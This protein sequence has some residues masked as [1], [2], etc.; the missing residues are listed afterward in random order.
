[1]GFMEKARDMATKAGDKANLVAEDMAQRARPFA[2]DLKHR[3]SPYA[4]KAG[5]LATK[6]VQAAAANVN[7]ATG[8]KYQDQIERISG[9]VDGAIGRLGD[10]IKNGHEERPDTGGQP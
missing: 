5:D 1:M 9:N 3:A 8:G 10:L 2:Q 6:G 7:K 4:E